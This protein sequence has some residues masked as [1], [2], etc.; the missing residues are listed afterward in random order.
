[1]NCVIISFI[2][3]LH[4]SDACNYGSEV[5][6]HFCNICRVTQSHIKSLLNITFL[7]ANRFFPSYTL[8]EIFKGRV[9]T[10]KPIRSF[11]IHCDQHLTFEINFFSFSQ[12][13]THQRRMPSARDLKR[14]PSDG[15]IGRRCLQSGSSC[16]AL[17]IQLTKATFSSSEKKNSIK[18]IY[19]HFHEHILLNI[20]LGSKRFICNKTPQFHRG[21][22]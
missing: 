10:L 5:E 16:R 12:P 6:T 14:L 11:P 4:I 19:Q 1:M 20:R 2:S 18:I 13:W 21:Q 8:V 3:S 9:L 7:Q 22:L 15:F 17:F